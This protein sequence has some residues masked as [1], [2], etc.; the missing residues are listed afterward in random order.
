M[1]KKTWTLLLLA[2]LLGSVYAYYF[3]DWINTPRIQI[4]KSDR[5]VRS[6]RFRMNVYPIT[7]TLDGRYELTSVRVFAA[8]EL[9]TN[10]HAKPLWHLVAKDHSEPVKGFLYGQ[11]IR[12]MQPAVTNARP[13]QLEPNVPYRLRLE[14]GRAKG[15]I[16]FQAAAL[17]GP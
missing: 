14:A 1:T 17:E 7:F 3:T 16:D 10:K 2:A 15:E 11:P 13:Q 12:G 6:Q 9:A 5:P 8:N 4:I